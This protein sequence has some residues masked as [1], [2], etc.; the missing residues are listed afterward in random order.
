[1]NNPKAMSYNVGFDL[2]LKG[3]DKE[4][5]TISKA[6]KEMIEWYNK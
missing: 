4:T 2:D 6:D 1:M 3:Y 5:E